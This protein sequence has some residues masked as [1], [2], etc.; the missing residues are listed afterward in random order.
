ML[1]YIDNFQRFS[2]F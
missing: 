1:L 2:I